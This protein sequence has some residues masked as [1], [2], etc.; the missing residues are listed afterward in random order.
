MASKCSVLLVFPKF[1]PKSFWSFEGVLHVVGA[2]YPAAPLGLITVAAMLPADWDVRL[3][4]RNTEELTDG[5][6]A[7]A[8]MVMT[9]GMF[10]QQMDTQ[11][12]IDECRARSI[13]VVVGG[14]DVTSSPQVYADADF[15]VVGE[16]EDALPP[17]VG[18]LDARRA[19]GFFRGAEIPGSTVRRT[20]IPRFDL[21]KF[22]HYLYIGVQF[23][24]GCPF[25]CE[26]CDIIELYGRVRAH[27][28]RRQQ[29]LAELDALYA[30]GYRGH[31]R[32]RR[33]QSHREQEGGKRISP[34]P[35]RMAEGAQ[36]SFHAIDGGIAQPL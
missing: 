22:N 12:I 11:E 31:A 30:L 10:A 26:F 14:P 6:L 32:F 35:H 28:D 18:G 16:A 17:F 23:S 13:P 7:W 24:R 8:D 36:L 21:L 15:R 4:N 29:M 20:P 9:G 3:V 19:A 1:N 5:D 27:Q 33:R 34:I 2:R 25:T